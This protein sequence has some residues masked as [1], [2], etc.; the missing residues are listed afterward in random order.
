MLLAFA[1]TDDKEQLLAVARTALKIPSSGDLSR[2]LIDVA[3]RYLGRND[4]ALHAAYFKAVGEHFVERGSAR[5]C[6]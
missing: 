1:Q 6:S 5:V 4:D 3:P 2:L